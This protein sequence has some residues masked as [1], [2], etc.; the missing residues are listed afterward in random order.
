MPSAR[1][2]DVGRL[3]IAMDDARARAR[4]RA[5]R[6]SG[7]RSPAPRRSARAAARSDRASVGAVDQLHHE[8]TAPAVLLEAVD[9]GDVRMIQR[10]EQLRLALEAR[11]PFGIAREQIRQH[12]DRDVAIEPRVGRAIDLALTARA[13]E[14][15]NLVTTET[16]AVFDWHENSRLYASL[17]V[18]PDRFDSA[19]GRRAGDRA[20]RCDRLAF[21]YKTICRGT[22][23]R[24]SVAVKPP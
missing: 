18:G 21:R 9:L 17:S 5:P 16:G 15:L 11:Q 20:L 14:G 7:A 3:Q 22:D 8:R 19:A 13:E 6:R 2:L 1:E 23:A 12:F 4:P 24:S 10:R